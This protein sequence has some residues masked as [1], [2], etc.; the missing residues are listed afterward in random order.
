MTRILGEPFT[1]AE[2]QQVIATARSFLGCP[3]KHQGR[4]RRGIDCLGLVA[5][6][7]DSVRPVV[8]RQ[9]YGRTPYNGALEASLREHFGPPVASAPVALADLKPADLLLMSWTSE[10]HHVAIVTPHPY[11]VG[12]IHSYS[13]TPN[14][15]GGGS[16]VEHRLS[17]DYLPLIQMVFRP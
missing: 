10:P 12:I 7:Y 14:N 1:D 8:D 13:I 17:D 11:G 5:L 9:G 2:R 3:W 15:A 6:A 16:V 4:T